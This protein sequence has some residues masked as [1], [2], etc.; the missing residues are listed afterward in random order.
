MTIVGH[1]L[2]PMCR[3]PWVKPQNTV[4]LQVH[5]LVVSRAGGGMVDVQYLIDGQY[6]SL[7]E[8]AKRAK[9]PTPIG[10]A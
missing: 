3:A 1:S 6:L 4:K 9:S 7:T 2:C 5:T 10:I 8:T